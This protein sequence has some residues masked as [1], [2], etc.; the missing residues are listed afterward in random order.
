METMRTQIWIICITIAAAIGLMGCTPTIV[1]DVPA[2]M[3]GEWH[4]QA[5]II[6]AWVEQETLPV[7]LTIH[8]DG[9]VEGH[10]GDATLTKGSIRKN[11][12][13]AK[14][15]IIMADLE[16][17]IVMAEDIVRDGVKM[18]VDFDGERLVGGVASTGSKTGGKETMILTA[19]GLVLTRV[20]TD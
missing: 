10:A 18:P 15:Y 11:L 14:Q 5:T 20:E 3:V 16:G 17:A 13:G 19:S 2:E 7:T 4:G 12:L 9:T 1:A 8:R 6:V